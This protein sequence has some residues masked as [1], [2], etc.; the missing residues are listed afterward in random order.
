MQ[1]V[2][3]QVSGLLLAALLL[4]A[5]AVKAET[6]VSAGWHNPPGA[7]FGANLMFA[8]SSF[9]LEL[10]V[11]RADGDTYNTD[12]AKD[13]TKDEEDTAALVTLGDIDLKYMFSSG[14]V[15][16]YVQGGF[17]LALAGRA[18][19]DSGASASTGSGFAGA[20]VLFKGSSLFGYIG[21][22]AFDIDNIKPQA[23][24]GIKL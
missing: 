3:S 13:G 5:P 20:G 12:A 23:G 2:I 17:G 8:G 14:G 22:Y 10:G 11:G 21:I 9:A 7:E 6:L 19:K 4:N 24:I 1:N 16:P 18:G 15:R